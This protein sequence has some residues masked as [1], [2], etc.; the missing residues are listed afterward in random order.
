MT[1]A[2]KPNW[3]DQTIWTGDNL[4]I[5][6][7]MNSETVDLIYLD[8][9]F[10]SNADYAAPKNFYECCLFPE[11]GDRRRQVDNRRNRNSSRS[12]KFADRKHQQPTGG[13]E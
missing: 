2:P 8:P 4:D 11:L 10:N 13:A 7:G 12:A 5:M 9:P 1:T 3:A 6:R